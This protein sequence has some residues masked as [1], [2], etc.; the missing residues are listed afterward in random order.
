M[1]LSRRPRRVPSRFFLLRYIAVGSTVACCLFASS[2]GRAQKATTWKHELSTWRAQ[3]AA[4]LQKPD[5]WLALAGLVWLE[6]GDNTVG[7]AADNK[8]RLP[9][10]GPAHVGVLH[11]EGTTVSLR[12]PAGG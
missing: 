6:P 8:A 10:S 12:P 4:E 7:S 9:A 3:H 11:L 2:F 1:P 5:G